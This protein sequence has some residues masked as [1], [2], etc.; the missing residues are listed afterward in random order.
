MTINFSQIEYD[1]KICDFNCEQEDLLSLLMLG[2]NFECFTVNKRVNFQTQVGFKNVLRT[3]LI[4]IFSE[5]N[6]LK[7]QGLDNNYTTL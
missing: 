1:N 5:R 7:P 3:G 6:S 2:I 4:Q